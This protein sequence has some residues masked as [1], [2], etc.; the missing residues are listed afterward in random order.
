MV[1]DRSASQLAHG[2]HH[3]GESRHG[4][5]HAV[6]GSMKSLV[7]LVIVAIVLGLIGTLFAGAAALPI[8]LILVV[9][10]ISIV[11][12]QVPTA[13]MAIGPPGVLG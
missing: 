4:W 1:I 8:M 13:N 10:T 12:D 2:V 6:E 9:P 11:I 5:C 3:A 7:F